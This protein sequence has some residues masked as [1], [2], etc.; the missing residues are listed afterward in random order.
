VKIFLDTPDLSV[1]EQWLPHGIVDGVTTNP[2]LLKKSGI[3]DWTGTV[4]ALARRIAPRDLSVQVSGVDHDDMVSQA[5][6]LASRGE[7]IVIK[8][9]VIS[10]DGQPHLD[11]MTTLREYGIPVNATVCL[12]AGQALAA[13]KAGARYA[14]LLWGRIGDEGGSPERVVA[15]VTGL[16]RRHG[17]ATRLLVGSVRAPAD[18]T[19]A[20]TA[21]ADAVTVPPALLG[22]WLDHRY[23][24]ATVRDF[25]ADAGVKYE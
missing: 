4:A 13:A 3:E 24:R 15:D 14:S 6:M 25:Q 10:P 7:N 20:L 21:G 23:A 1:V 18:I 22:R 9:P 12:S 16:L 19:R 5:K 8:V 2:T 11:V 17:L